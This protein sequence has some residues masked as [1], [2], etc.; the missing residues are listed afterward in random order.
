MG[1]S[2]YWFSCFV[3]DSEYQEI[4]PSFERAES[5]AILSKK[6]E[7]GIEFW[8]RNQ[9]NVDWY[10]PDGKVWNDFLCAFDLAG[11]KELT[12]SICKS[13]EMF[14]NFL[15]EQNV[16]RFIIINNYTPVSILWYALGFE[17]SN[18][19]PGKMGNL[20]VH[21]TE[22]NK[23]LKEVDEIFSKRKQ[24]DLISKAKSY[25]EQAADEKLIL[26]VITMMQKGLEKAVEKGK[27]IFF[28]AS[29]QL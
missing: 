17:S 5:N 18:R 14:G 21:S 1:V 8:K 19:L 16:H 26:E 7:M 4:L 11:Y 6:S 20:L 23:L 10:G 29:A 27:G 28:L 22:V 25:V 9:A 13:G 24:E 2:H 3:S 12:T 15:N